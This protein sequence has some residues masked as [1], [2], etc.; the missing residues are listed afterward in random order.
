MARGIVKD[1]I[2]DNALTYAYAKTNK[3]NEIESFISGANNVDAQKVGDKCYDDKLY[4]AAKIL[5][6]SLKNN[7]KI[8][9]C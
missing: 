9:S 7:S 8:A 4:E 3:L 1:A 2:I 6:V 5:F